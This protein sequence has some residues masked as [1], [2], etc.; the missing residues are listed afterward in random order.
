MLH[1]DAP[2]AGTGATAAAASLPSGRM[3]HRQRSISTVATEKERA[4]LAALKQAESASAWRAK[5]ARGLRAVT[6]EAKKHLML[7]G[8]FDGGI[9]EARLRELYRVLRAEHADVHPYMV[10]AHGGDAFGV[11]TVRG[12]QGMYAMVAFAFDDYGQATGSKYSSF[13][14]VKYAYEKSVPIIPVKLCAQ[15]P[16][17]PPPSAAARAA[18]K[19]LRGPA[20]GDDAQQVPHM[21]D[22]VFTQDLVYLD[23]SEREWDAAECARD[24]AALARGK[25]KLRTASLAEEGG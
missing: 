8:R 11:Q 17:N 21:N 25:Q 10:E 16:P 3:Q 5:M 13:Y 14:E 22:L 7:S 15:W 1:N 6:R 4:A 18:R 19:S 20:G 23:W 24:V 12:V 9:K 2:P